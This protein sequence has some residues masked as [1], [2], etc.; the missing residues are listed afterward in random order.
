MFSYTYRNQKNNEKGIDY[1]LFSCI[2]NLIYDNIAIY[3][4]NVNKIHVII[5][6]FLQ[7]NEIKIGYIYE[8]NSITNIIRELKD[9]GL[10]IYPKINIYKL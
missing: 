7:I 10:N 9:K 4:K 2:P 8:R 1:L 5:I 3:G 6:F